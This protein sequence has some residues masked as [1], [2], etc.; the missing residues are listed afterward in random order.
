MNA[1]RPVKEE[2]TRKLERRATERR[3]DDVTAVRHEHRSVRLWFVAELVLAAP[4][5]WLWNHRHDPAVIAWFQPA[6]VV[7]A[8]LA[9]TLI[10]RVLFASATF[11]VMRALGS[12]WPAAWAM[13]SL[14]PILDVLL[15]GLL[16]L[17]VSEFAR[18][19]G[20]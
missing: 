4:A 14:I 17:L 16:E 8:L 3:V 1:R 7:A 18:K 10:A 19:R 13:V 15:L 5:Y 2:L 11:R 9:F 20:T 6:M 12:Q